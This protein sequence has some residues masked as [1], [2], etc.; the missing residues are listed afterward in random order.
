VQGSK[1]GLV[2]PCGEKNEKTKNGNWQGALLFGSK[3]GHWQ[4]LGESG[5]FNIF[6]R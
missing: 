4:Q 1:S 2:F 5:V 6:E 3:E